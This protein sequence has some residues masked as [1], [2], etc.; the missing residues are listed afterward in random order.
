[1]LALLDH[2]KDTCYRVPLKLIEREDPYALGGYILALRYCTR[3]GEATGSI[4]QY[5]RYF[6]VNPD[7]HQGNTNDRMREGLITLAKMGVF[8]GKRGTDVR[9]LVPNEMFRWKFASEWGWD[10]KDYPLGVLFSIAEI[11]YSTRVAK[12]QRWTGLENYFQILYLMGYL[13]CFMEV[14]SSDLTPRKRWEQAIGIVD[15][16]TVRKLLGIGANKL[17]MRLQR[18]NTSKLGLIRIIRL[19]NKRHPKEAG[20][21]LIVAINK[22]DREMETLL[23]AKNGI[24]RYYEG[25]EMRIS[26]DPEEKAGGRP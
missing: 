21:T 19:T 17:L 14:P 23:R 12:S 2:T 15:F 1:M 16:N 4:N 9:K 5:L 8:E 26:K 10:F 7:S 24:R 13:R 3:F 20:P 18:I 6:G 22:S 25:Y 11:E